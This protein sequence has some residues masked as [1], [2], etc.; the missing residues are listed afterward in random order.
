MKNVKTIVIAATLMSAAVFTGCKKEGALTD[1]TPM[2]SEAA[3]ARDQQP[4][5]PAPQPVNGQAA[6][7][8]HF[9]IFPTAT[10]DP[11]Q[12]QKGMISVADVQMQ[13]TFYYPDGTQKLAV[14]YA[15][16]TPA[17]T[18]SLFTPNDVIGKLPLRA[19]K[20]DN[21]SFRVLL[22][23]QNSPSLIL[24]GTYMYRGRRIPLQFVVNERVTLWA[25]W[26]Q[27]QYLGA[28]G[29][30]GV[31][32]FIKG[33]SLVRGIDPLMMER[34]INQKN[35]EQ[36][37]TISIQQNANLYNIMLGNLQ[38]MATGIKLG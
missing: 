30:S 34:A 13:G 25:Q 35:P 6:L 17:T 9:N 28:E 32:L 14:S 15:N 12:W 2:S 37:I 31:S 4:V 36:G 21:M 19:G 16:P 8:Y 38:K 22:A 11:Y 10:T 7:A 24:A 33:E 27:M 18:Y 5:P 1:V 3:T 29:A 20:Y 23:T 26:P